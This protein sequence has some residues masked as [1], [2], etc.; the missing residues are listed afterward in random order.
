MVTPDQPKLSTTTTDIVTSLCRGATGM[1]PVIGPLIAEII[2]N[3]IPN[4]RVARIIRFVQLLDERLQKLE[5]GLLESKLTQPAGVD[6]LEDA[7]TQASRATSDERL[8]HI[9]NVVANGLSEDEWNQAQSKRLLWLLGQLDD[10]EIVILRSKLAMTRGDFDADSD[11]REKHAELLAPDA[12]HMGSSE[13]EFETK[14]LRESYR[15]HLHDL[16]LIRTRYQKPRRNDFP[17]FDDKTGM[18]KASGTNIT[19]LGQMLLRS[20]CLIPPW[21]KY[22]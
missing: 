2:G 22:S 15:R 18:M 19:R 20:L 7:F 4:Q 13:D 9:A 16:G 11:F 8:E 1:V 6:L 5:R 21:Y 12:T 3:I 10:A 14:A 17:E